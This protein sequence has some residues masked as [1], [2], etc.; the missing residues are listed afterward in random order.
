MAAVGAAAV[1]PH[2]AVA[3]AAGPAEANDASAA[4]CGRVYRCT[5]AVRSAAAHGVARVL[6]V[7]VA[8]YVAVKVTEVLLMY[9]GL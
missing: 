4:R 9:G 8:T 1:S 5:A 2:Q 6:V 7:G 3:G